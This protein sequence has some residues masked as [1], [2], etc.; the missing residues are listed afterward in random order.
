M[1]G[2]SDQEPLPAA[3]ESARRG[4]SPDLPAVSG[5]SDAVTSSVE[6]TP[7]PSDP[8]GGRLFALSERYAGPLPPPKYLAAY[9]EVLPGAAERLLKQVETEQKHR[10]KLELKE[11]DRQ[12]TRSLTENTVALRA[13]PYAFGFAALTVVTGGVAAAC[14]AELGGSA[15]AIAA[16]GL[17][18][19][20][21]LAK[22][23][24]RWR[25]LS[26]RRREKPDDGEA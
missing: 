24:V 20:A 7:E 3:D 9:E 23:R 10:H 4:E 19:S 16:V 21:F 14:G 5:T 22:G 12:E 15:T 13:Q 2:P 18:A 8:T 25:G 1:S 6:P 11:A 26:P 17:V